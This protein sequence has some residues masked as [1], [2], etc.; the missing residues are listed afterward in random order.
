M[1]P[2]P[3][4]VEPIACVVCGREIR[5][6]YRCEHCPAIACSSVCMQLHLQALHPRPKPSG[7]GGM[8]VATIVLGGLVLMIMVGALFLCCGGCSFLMKKSRTQQE[9]R[10][11]TKKDKVPPRPILPD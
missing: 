5:K 7:C 2:E 1:S 9:P 10:P 11:A 6:T 8:A 4:M 3:A